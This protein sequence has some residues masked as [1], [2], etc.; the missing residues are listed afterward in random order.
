MQNLEKWYERI[1]LQG[2][3]GETDTE[4]RLMDTGRGEERVR[5]KERVTWKLRLPYVK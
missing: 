4:N 1:Y 2:N 3:N 5:C